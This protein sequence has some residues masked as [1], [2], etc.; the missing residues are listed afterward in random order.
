[1]NVSVPAFRRTS[2][3]RYLTKWGGANRYFGR[4]RTRAMALYADSLREWSTWRQGVE[5]AR[6]R[7]RAGD[8][9]LIVL[10]V[11]EQHL[12]ARQAEGGANLREYYR[13]SLA[14]FAALFARWWADEIRGK[15]IAAMVRAMRADGYAAKTCNHESIAIK[16]AFRWAAAN[17]RIPPVN[18]DGCKAL[19][20]E[21]PTDKSL[22]LDVVKF[23]VIKAPPDLQPWVATQYLGA[24]RPCEIVRLV[25]GDGDWTQEGIFTMRAKRQIRHVVLSPCALGWLARCRPA[26]SRA[27]DYSA[28]LRRF[29]GAGGPH[30]LRHSAATHL[31]QAGVSR[32]NTDLILGHK[33]GRV[34]QIYARIDWQELRAFAARLSL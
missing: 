20:L 12:D 30:P 11:I 15:H 7:R 16:A 9:R 5:H 3:G 24:M 14:R 1:M 8:T 10:D 18:L 28:A 26:W 6:T 34:S 17:E 22:S 23:M 19:A 32:A 2:D 33:I 4:D 29:F 31:H 25:A 13:G 27:G 21:E